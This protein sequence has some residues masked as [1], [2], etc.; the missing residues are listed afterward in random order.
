MSE[1]SRK[2]ASAGQTEFSFDVLESG[3]SKHERE[4]GSDVLRASGKYSSDNSSTDGGAAPG[5]F[6]EPG[7]TPPADRLYPHLFGE[8][9]QGG[10]ALSLL[11]SAGKDCQ[12]ALDAYAQGDFEEVGSRLS[13]VAAATAAAHRLLQF[14]A[15]LGAVVGFVRRAVLR[16]IATEVTRPGLNV[17]KST[18]GR[19]ARAPVLDMNEAAELIDR[20]ASEGWDGELEIVNSAIDL[21][22]R[23][24]DSQGEAE[25]VVDGQRTA[26]SAALQRAR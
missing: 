8:G 7:R 17:L 18:L 25:R 4:Q 24:D 14:S 9:A 10:E 16:S 26:V 1:I 20:F 5:G 23:N 22:L 12:V 6:R 3:G 11:C 13:S 21:L 2:R 15:P 19:L